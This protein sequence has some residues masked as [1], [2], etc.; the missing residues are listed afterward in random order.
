MEATEIKEE[1]DRQRQ[2]IEAVYVYGRLQFSVCPRCGQKQMYK[3]KR[4]EKCRNCGV[5]RELNPGQD[6]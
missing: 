5:V 4:Q 1:L 2:Y 3:Y 6:F